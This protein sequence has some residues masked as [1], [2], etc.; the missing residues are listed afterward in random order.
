MTSRGL[1]RFVSVG[2]CQLLCTWPW[3]CSE[4]SEQKTDMWWSRDGR[5]IFRGLCASELIEYTVELQIHVTTDWLLTGSCYQMYNTNAFQSSI[6]N[7]AVMKVLPYQQLTLLRKCFSWGEK[8]TIDVYATSRWM[9]EDV[10]E[11]HVLSS[12][13]CQ[14][15]L[16]Q[17]NDSSYVPNEFST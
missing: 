1:R 16:I 9:Q 4:N 10:W 15:F 8:S 13:L 11:C 17:L 2:T 5:V 6:L 7:Q 3:C 12:H 14:A